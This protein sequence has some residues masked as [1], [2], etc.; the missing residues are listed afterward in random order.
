MAALVRW[1]FAEDGQEILDNASCVCLEA[2]KDDHFCWISLPQQDF[3][4]T[5]RTVLVKAPQLPCLHGAPA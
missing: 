2:D 5:M 1:M 4:R 3:L